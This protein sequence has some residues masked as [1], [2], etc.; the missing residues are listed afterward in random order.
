MPLILELEGRAQDQGFQK[1]SIATIQSKGRVFS[2]RR[3]R[4]VGAKYFSPLSPPVIS[5]LPTLY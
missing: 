1:F 3:S 2:A 5:N 4:K